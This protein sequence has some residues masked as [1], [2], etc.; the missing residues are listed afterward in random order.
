MCQETQ[1]EGAP[2]KKPK[3]NPTTHQLPSSCGVNGHA[4]MHASENYADLHDV[5]IWLS[6]KGKDLLPKGKKQ[7]MALLHMGR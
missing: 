7:A 3:N 6:S 5:S 1:A 2:E 4:L